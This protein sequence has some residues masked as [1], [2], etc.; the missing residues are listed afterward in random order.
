MLKNVVRKHHIQDN[1]CKPGQ[2]DTPPWKP[3][4]IG[5]RKKK[6]KTK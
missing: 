4:R 1:D 6:T 3:E 2:G 5:T